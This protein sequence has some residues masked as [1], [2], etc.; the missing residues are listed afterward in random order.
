MTTAREL[1]L[2]AE[3]RQGKKTDACIDFEWGASVWFD[4]TVWCSHESKPHW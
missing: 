3:T 2:M 4:C 1:I